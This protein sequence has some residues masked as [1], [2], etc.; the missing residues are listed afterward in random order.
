MTSTGPGSSSSSTR[1]PSV[2]APIAATLFSYSLPEIPQTKPLPPVQFAPSQGPRLGVRPELNALIAHDHI[3]YPCGSLG[4]W[5]VIRF[6]SAGLLLSFA[7]RFCFTI[8]F[9]LHLDSSSISSTSALL[10]PDDSA[11]SF[12]KYKISTTLRS[13]RSLFVPTKSIRNMTVA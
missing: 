6:W 9:H 4:Y 10:P 8:F 1:E 12:L 7:T 3:L 13:G 11:T 5:L 2:E